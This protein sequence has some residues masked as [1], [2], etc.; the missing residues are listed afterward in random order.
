MTISNGLGK[1]VLDP[2]NPATGPLA[3]VNG[4]HVFHNPVTFMNTDHNI[5]VKADNQTTN[6][7]LSNVTSTT[8]PRGRIQDKSAMTVFTTTRGNIN[9]AMET[10]VNIKGPV[11]TKQFSYLD[12][13]RTTTKETSLFSWNGGIT[14]NVPNQMTQSHYTSKDGSGGSTSIPTNKNPIIGYIP[15]GSRVTGNMT[16]VSPGEVNIK[17]FDNDRICTEGPGTLHQAV[18][19][20][21]RINHVFKEQVG[22]VQANPNKLQQEDYSRTDS[23]LISG[24]LNNGFSIYN[25]GNTKDLVYPS[26]MCNSRPADYSPYKTTTVK[27][28]EIPERDIPRAI[29]IHNSRRNGNEVIVRNVTSGNTENPLLFTK[30]ELICSPSIHGKCYSG[31]LKDSGL[32]TDAFTRD[33]ARYAQPPAYYGLNNAVDLNTKPFTGMFC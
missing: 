5:R 24:L 7:Q 3:P 17:E 29:P 16:Q 10:Q 32:A 8:A 20:L 30:R 14:N 31:N 21:S 25:N 28:E 9:P 26:F 11:N 19:E 33:T 27:K 6:H 1:V 13:A 2:A 18:P 4:G 23:A 15:G 12:G 22:S